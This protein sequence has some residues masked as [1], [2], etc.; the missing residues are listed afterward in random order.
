M[1]YNLTHCNE[2]RV[3]VDS[4]FFNVPSLNFWKSRAK[5]VNEVYKHVE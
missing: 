1:S 4:R 3:S 5:L 2:I